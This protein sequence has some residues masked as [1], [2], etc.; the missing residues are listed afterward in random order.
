MTGW[1]PTVALE[2]A[3]LMAG[4]LALSAIAMRRPDLIVLA[5]PFGVGTALALALRTRG[6]TPTAEMSVD[7][8]AL[9]ES[10]P[11]TVRVRAVGAADVVSV[12]LPGQWLRPRR[13]G[14]GDGSR[15]RGRGNQYSRGGLARAT[16]LD[17]D[18]PAELTF[19]LEPVRWGRAPVGPVRVTAVTA[20][21]LL[22]SA[23]LVVPL[24]TVLVWP[25]REAFVATDLVPRAE[26]VVGPHRSRRPGEGV[27]ING[28]RPFQ[29]GDRLRRINWRVTMRRS[30]GQPYLG[31]GTTYVTST[32][33]DRDTDVVL[34]VDSWVDLGGSL[35]TAVR[36]ATGVAEYYLRAGDR[37]GLIDLG[38]PMR[39]VRQGNG[40]AHLARILD[41]LLD[42]RDR[43][44]RVDRQ[45]P[46]ALRELPAHAL[47]VVLTP[48]L[49]DEVVG[50]IAALARS[51]RPVIA[52]DTLP[53]G[54]R[55]PPRGE[56]TDLAWRVSGLERESDIGR[57]AEVGVPVVPW[58]G[59]RSLDDVLR[60]ASQLVRLPRAV[61]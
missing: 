35:D 32:L 7:P 11:L 42:V 52:V 59:A 41:V 5:A 1:R 17:T 9:L 24:R 58:R 33:S 14:R 49:G 12:A 34:C 43:P 30:A 28:V 61:R 47:V 10:D 50:V 37:V 57:L 6:R 20:Y 39:R 48:L 38:Q 46:R 56:W 2:R 45:V 13:R 40:R 21:G 29:P 27:E 15:R 44:S 16:V 53:E 8:P 18:R 25:L 60:D 4:G 26:G 54:F 19:D 55:P 22:R 31:S 36:A 3:L 51:N 23:P